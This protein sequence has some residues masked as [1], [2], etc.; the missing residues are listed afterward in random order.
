MI[1]FNC[2]KLVRNNLAFKALKIKLKMEEG[3]VNCLVLGDRAVGKSSVL[4]R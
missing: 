2:Q 1:K 4:L 3:V